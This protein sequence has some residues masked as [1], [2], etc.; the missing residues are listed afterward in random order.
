MLLPILLAAALVLLGVLYLQQ[1]LR[2]KSLQQLLDAAVEEKHDIQLA[3]HRLLE[4]QEILQTQFAEDKQQVQRQFEITAQQLLQRVSGN[5]LEQNQLKLVNVLQPLS[6]K[7]ESFRGAMQQSLLAE[8]S[9]RAALRTE[10]QQLLQLNQTLTREANNLTNA[11]KADTKKQ[12]NW[13]EMILERV[14]EA[15]GLEKNVHYQV[16]DSRRDENGRQYRPDVILQLPEHRQLVI[17]SKVSLKAY[18]GY[19]SAPSEE[20]KQ[21][22]L[23]SHLQSVKN[24]IDELS[25]KNYSVLYDNST[26]FVLLFVPIEPAYTLAVMQ[27]DD[28]YDYAFRKRIVMV[29]VPALLATLRI[30]NSMWKLEQQNRNA[31]EIVRQGT[32]LYDKF[33]GFAEDLRLVGT[34]MH[35]SQEAFDNALAKLSTGK[36]NLMARAQHMQKLGLNSKKELPKELLDKSE[37]T[38]PED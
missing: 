26:D 4:R 5:L 8:T 38:T 20:E 27:E 13:G 25:H 30:I 37:L 15:S 12:G 32:A 16:Q 28:L 10:L 18:E 3:H 23:R 17:D 14:L 29:S 6:E 11:L 31:T 9:Q 19:C 35:K 24:H 7:I 21:T 22:F 2:N 36:G 1:Q 34:Q 33:V